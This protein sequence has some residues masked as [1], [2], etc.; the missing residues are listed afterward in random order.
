MSKKETFLQILEQELPFGAWR[1]ISR[2]AVVKI[3]SR[4]Y[5]NLVLREW[6]ISELVDNGKKFIIKWERRVIPLTDKQVYE[7]YGK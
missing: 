4:S 2:S 7:E 3:I 6:Y 1:E 5:S